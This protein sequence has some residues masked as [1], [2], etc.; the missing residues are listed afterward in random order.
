[1]L[2][3]H[4]K[5]GPLPLSLPPVSLVIKPA[6]TEQNSEEG[7]ALFLPRMTVKMKMNMNELKCPNF[8]VLLL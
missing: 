1:M 3:S 8:S 2:E 7:M 5:H 4:G 6:E